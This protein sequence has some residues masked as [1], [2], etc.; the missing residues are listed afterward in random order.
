LVDGF[1]GEGNEIIGKSVTGDLSRYSGANWV[2]GLTTV[3]FTDEAVCGTK[4]CF[5]E[6]TCE[7]CGK[8]MPSGK[9]FQKGRVSEMTRRIMKKV[10]V[11][12]LGKSC[13]FAFGFVI[14]G[15]WTM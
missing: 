14:G 11:S 8:T 6:L 9:D 5:E 15:P 12:N 1:D 10:H 2:L 3:G 13:P 4:V 7:P